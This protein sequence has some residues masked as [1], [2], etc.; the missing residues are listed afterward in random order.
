MTNY[1]SISEFA[2]RANVTKQAIYKRIKTDPD[3]APYVK[4]QDGKKTVSE[5]ALT[6]FQQDKTA[7][8]GNKQQEAPAGYL[9]ERISEQADTIEEQRKE[10]EYLRGLLKSADE[11]NSSLTQHLMESQNKQLELQKNYQILLGAQNPLLKAVNQP[12]EGETESKPA[13][14]QKSKQQE[15][16]EERTSIFSKLFK[17]DR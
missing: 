7:P 5:A 4:E 8:A 10:I 11:R 15:K 13:E 17:H 3:F 2:E 9:L 1:I 6:I 12:V 14:Q 16:T